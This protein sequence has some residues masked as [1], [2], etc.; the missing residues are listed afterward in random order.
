MQQFVILARDQVD[1]T[2]VDNINTV[3]LFVIIILKNL[4]YE[5]HV[6]LI[7][8]I[9]LQFLICVFSQLSL[10]FLKIDFGFGSETGHVSLHD[11]IVS[12]GIR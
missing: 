1:T 9:V 6:H 5:L 4:F 3:H 7:F 11:G 2:F 8:C 10:D 12:F